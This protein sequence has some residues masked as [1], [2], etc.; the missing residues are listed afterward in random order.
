VT[1]EHKKARALLAESKTLVER[2][3]ITEPK[4]APVVHERQFKP[5]AKVTHAPPERLSRDVSTRR[6]KHLAA[7]ETMA[8]TLA[9]TIGE[10][11]GRDTCASILKQYSQFPPGSRLVGCGS[12]LAQTLRGV[13]QQLRERNFKPAKSPAFEGVFTK[14][15]WA[16]ANEAMADYFNGVKK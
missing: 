1:K 2:A 3:K 6:A 4:A 11:L 16:G 8:C 12:A 10:D 14:A 5:P 7:E 15:F 9:V 13:M